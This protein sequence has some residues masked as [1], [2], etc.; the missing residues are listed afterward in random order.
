MPDVAWNLPRGRRLPVGDFLVAF[1][2]S[3]T[4]PLCLGNSSPPDSPPLQT[5][6]GASEARAEGGSDDER[7]EGEGEAEGGG[8]AAGAELQREPRWLADPYDL[9]Y[10]KQTLR[11]G[12]VVDRRFHAA[13]VTGVNRL[14]RALLRKVRGMGR[15]QR[16]GGMFSMVSHV[17]LRPR[18]CVPAFTCLQPSTLTFAPSARCRPPLLAGCAPG[19]VA[20]YPRGALPQA[21]AGAA[22][23]AAAVGCRHGGGADRGAAGLRPAPA[24][25]RA[26][27]AVGLAGGEASLAGEPC[28]CW[29]W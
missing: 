12:W 15:G 27:G 21:E 16:Q 3:R 10:E 28:W 19:G 24:G 5:C 6:A 29:M 8:A 18:S 26:A 20:P 22:A 13:H 4:V 9:R 23:A 14:P 11:A 1:M 25:W 2:P 17:M 7:G